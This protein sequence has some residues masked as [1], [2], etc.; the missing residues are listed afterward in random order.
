MV[1]KF[2][3]IYFFSHLNEI[4]GVETHLYYLAKKYKER[5]WCVMIRSGDPEQ[6]KRI[7]K[8]VR[9]FIIKPMDRIECDKLFF[10]Y[11]SAIAN[12]VKANE[13]YY[14][15]HT[16]YQTQ[17]DNG[18]MPVGS[19]V[20]HPGWKYLAVSEAAKNGFKDND[21]IDVVY[22][23]IEM[24]KSEEPILLMSATRLTPEK[25]WNRM[26]VLINALDK[27]SVNYMWHI[28]TNKEP[29]KIS[30]NVLFI[31]PRLDITSKM[32]LYDA[33]VQL[34]DV[35]AFCITIQEAL[36]NGLHLICTPLPLIE[37][38][39]AE[40][41]TITLPFDMK[42]I[43]AQVEQIRHIKEMPKVNY[44]P[45]KEKWG[46]LLTAKKTNYNEEYLVVEATNGYERNFL[47]DKE[48]GVVP[49]PGQTWQVSKDRLIEIQKWEREHNTRLVNVI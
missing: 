12:Q 34:S 44:K 19:N 20:K 26:K 43:D 32:K 28:Y 29:E 17:I 30:E 9:L 6:I 42:D 24:D 23:P 33:M 46:K 39:K 18:T 47:I 15:I 25:G 3:T 36:M 21:D 1:Y 16:D 22:M 48:L 38:I 27:A 14:V 41:F 10:T 37:E 35:E 2:N 8:L 45:P 31:K 11:D 13:Y 49:K 4:G 40:E 7:S 5:D